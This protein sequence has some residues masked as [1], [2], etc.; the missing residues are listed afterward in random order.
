M[1]NDKIDNI[2]QAV[3]VVRQ[4]GD[5]LPQVANEIQRA[6]VKRII[7]DAPVVPD[8]HQ[9]VA[10]EIGPRGQYLDMSEWHAPCGTRHCRAGWVVALAGAVGDA[11]G[12]AAI[13][14]E[15]EHGTALA[16]AAIYFASDPALEAVPD[17]YSSDNMA[18]RQI[19]NSAWRASK[20]TPA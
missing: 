19:R 16:A 4:D 13:A 10:Y 2:D 20:L 3:E 12:K 14:L 8:I 1:E 7:P 11:E 18:W 15:A 17:F 5:A 9:A 6:V